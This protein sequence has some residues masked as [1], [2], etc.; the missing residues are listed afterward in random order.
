MNNSKIIA[1]GI[2]KAILI[3]AAISLGFIFLAQIQTIL[4]YILLSVIIALIANPLVELLRNK[5]KFNNTLAVIT[6]LLVFIL[7]IFGLIMLFVPLIVAQSKNLSL[8]DTNSIKESSLELYQ[9]VDSYLKNKNIDLSK[10]INENDIISS[11]KINQFS[12]FFSSIITIISNLGIGVASTLFITF[13]LLKDKVA[14]LIG[15]KKILRDDR[16]HRILNSADKIKTMLT[17]YFI[18]LIIQLT[19]VCIL[20]LIVLLIFGVENAIVIAF[21]CA[22]LNIIPYIGPMIGSVLAG[23]LTMLSNINN[24]FQTVTLPTTIYVTIGFF[25][26]QLIDNNISSPIIFSKSVNSHPLEIFL[27]VLISGTLFGIPGMII[28]VPL[29]TII[30]VIAKEFYPNNKIVKEITKNL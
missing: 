1:F 2:I 22:I 21:L 5:L 12:H 13:F 4:I 19:V 10:F 25:I 28:A 18:G 30:K 6:T 7:L 3:L 27:V 24:D 15:I 26:V 11:L 14:F 20:Y 16:E 8:L 9:Q 29:Y 23:L 17:R